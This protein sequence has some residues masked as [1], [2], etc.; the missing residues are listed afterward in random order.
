MKKT[1]ILGGTF[2]PVHLG[3]LAIG[4]AAYEEYGLDR[5]LFMPTA[6]SYLKDQKDILSADDRMTI[7]SLAIENEAGFELSDYEVVKGG[8]TYTYETLEYFRKT[9]PEE[10]LFFI[11]GADTLFSID[12][13]RKPERIF[14][15]AHL[16]VAVR[17]EHSEKEY[18]DRILYLK[19]RFSADIGLLSCKRM[20]ISSSFIRKRIKE[21]GDV[22]EFLPKRVC[23][24]IREKKLYI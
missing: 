6:I 8:N 7:V 13:W 11:T 17:D 12:T 9:D 15:L 16:L 3:H 14:E 24:Y 4:R 2:N 20:D 1:G 5:V 22:S 19:E 23:E 10:E 18:D 21:G